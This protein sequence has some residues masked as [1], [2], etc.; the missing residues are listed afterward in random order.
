MEQD[1]K[2]WVPVSIE[3]Y[4]LARWIRSL[5]LSSIWLPESSDVEVVVSDLFP[6]RCSELAITKCKKLILPRTC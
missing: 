6:D 4:V 2:G 1:P 3:K 5:Q